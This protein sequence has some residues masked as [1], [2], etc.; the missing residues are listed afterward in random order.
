[1]IVKEFYMTRKDGVGLYRTYSDSDVY[2]RKIGTNEEYLEAI[3]IE[4]SLYEYEETEKSINDA[5]EDDNGT[6]NSSD[7]DDAIDQDEFIED[8]EEITDEEFLDMLEEVL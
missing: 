5:M 4:T 6:D 1:M 3:D 8:N 7:T 2:I